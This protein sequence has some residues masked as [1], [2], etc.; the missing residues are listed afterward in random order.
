M[1][2]SF[3]APVPRR[4]EDGDGP[5]VQPSFRRY[6]RILLGGDLIG[7]EIHD[8]LAKSNDLLAT[9]AVKELATYFDLHRALS[10]CIVV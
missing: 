5:L 8:E 4:C 2:G 9:P 10:S 3:E 1:R 7:G 6:L